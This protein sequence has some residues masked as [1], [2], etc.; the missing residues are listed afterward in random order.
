MKIL[1]LGSGAREHAIVKALIR[2]GTR[3][4]DITCAPGNGGI[5]QEVNCVDLN[6]NDPAAVTSWAKQNDVHLVVIG[7]EAPLVAGV[8]D[9]LRDA[10]IAV[11]GPSRAAAALEGSKAFAKEVMAAADVPTGMAR[12][13]TSIYEVEQALEEFGAPYVVKADGLAAGKGVIVTSDKQA[14]LDHANTFLTQGMKILVEEF[15]DGEEVSL[16]FLADGTSAL[17]LSPAQDF[18]R[19]YDN[20]EGPNTG[21]MGAYSPL[22]WLPEGFVEE[23]QTR[24]ALPTVR[25]LARLGTPFVGLLYCGLIVTSKGIRVIEFN[26]RFGDPETQVVLRR[27]QTPLSHL[28]HS[29]AVGHLGELPEPEFSEEVAV[30]VVLASEGYPVS[31]A[32]NREI[33]GL[34]ADSGTVEIAHAATKLEDGKLVATGGRV[35]SVVSTAD[36]FHQSREQAYKVI[37]D[38][39]LEGSHYRSDIA[40]KVDEEHNV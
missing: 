12:K 34:V 23:V 21:G 26:A 38:I 8:S 30:T 17:P 24:V 31:A 4:S 28:L 35:L 32:P 10:G 25:E 7:P 39:K 27:L 6:P 33:S 15:L 22:P 1:V 5:S 14:A 20:D 2:T 19:A 18:K 16:F 11:F 29:A 40:L 37:K 9:A 3:P 36:S 13:C